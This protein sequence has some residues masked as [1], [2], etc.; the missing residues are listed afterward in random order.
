V[1]NATDINLVS[2]D[3][4]GQLGT[5]DTD[6]PAGVSLELDD[7]VRGVDDFLVNFAPFL[8]VV[9]IFTGYRK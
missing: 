6:A 3:G 2:E 9:W 4:V 1:I 7:V 8:V 5:H